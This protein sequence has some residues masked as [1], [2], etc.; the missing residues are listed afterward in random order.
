LKSYDQPHPE[1][2]SVEQERSG[3]SWGKEITNKVFEDANK[4]SCWNERY[5]TNGERL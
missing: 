5:N 1:R 2:G 4:A 3:Y